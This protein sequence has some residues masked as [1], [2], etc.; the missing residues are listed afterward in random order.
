MVPVVVLL[1]DGVKVALYPV[2]DPANP[3]IEPPTTSTSAE[4]KSAEDSERVNVS[5]T[6][7][8]EFTT[9]VLV[10]IAIVGTIVSIL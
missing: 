10:V 4:V 5:P 8:P 2:P 9:P 1:A 6:V 7:E 3:D